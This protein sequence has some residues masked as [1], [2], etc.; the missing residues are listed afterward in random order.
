MG[1]EPGNAMA[2]LRVS[3]IIIIL[4]QTLVLVLL[5]GCGPKTTVCISFFF[6]ET[7]ASLESLSSSARHVHILCHEHVWKE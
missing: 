1:L 5:D 6:A 2:A 3:I 7:S 4:K